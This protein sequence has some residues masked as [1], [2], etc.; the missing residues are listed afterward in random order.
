MKRLITTFVHKDMLVFDPFSGSGS[1]GR[2]CAELGI[3]F[4]G[5]EIDLEYC[6]I[7]NSRIREYHKT[8]LQQKFEL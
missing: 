5:C 1:T 2:A 3:N 7:A 8:N 4:V 6:N